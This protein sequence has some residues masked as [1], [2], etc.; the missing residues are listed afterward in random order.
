MCAGAFYPSSENSE[1]PK[2]Y[3]SRHRAAI[4]ISEI[5]DAFTIVLSEETGR[6]ATT[7]AGTI[8]G[9]TTLDSLRISLKQN[10]IVK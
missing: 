1:I 6:I 9:N 7:I 10:I 4:G 5:T 8:T 3:G 2:H